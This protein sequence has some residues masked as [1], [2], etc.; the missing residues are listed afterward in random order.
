MSRIHGQYITLGTNKH[1]LL[2]KQE[3]SKF[4]GGCL[5]NAIVDRVFE[6]C[7]S[8]SGEIDYK[9]YLDFVL[10]R[11]NSRTPQAIRFFFKLLDVQH[12][13]YI[14]LYALNHFWRSMQQH[15]MIADMETVSFEDIK[16]EIFDMVRFM[17]VCFFF[18]FFVM[19]ILVRAVIN[20]EPRTR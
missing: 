11:E 20:C 2:S 10:A 13:G 7:L 19:I 15:P 4:D 14:N 8:Y 18:L 12:C 3:F 5:T 9:V 1:G 16:N 6:E 17:R